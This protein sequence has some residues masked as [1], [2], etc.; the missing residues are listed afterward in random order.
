MHPFVFYKC[1]KAAHR[2]D[3]P[4][5]VTLGIQ[6]LSGSLSSISQFQE[7]RAMSMPRTPKAAVGFVDQ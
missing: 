1:D 2:Y 5:S 3:Y 4:S 6:L 7:Y